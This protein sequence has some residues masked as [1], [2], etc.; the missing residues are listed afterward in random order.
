MSE[1]DQEPTDKKLRDARDKGEVVRSAEAVSALVFIGVLVALWAG[2]TVLLQHLYA[3]MHHALRIISSPDPAAQLGLFID[4]LLWEWIILA[5]PLLVLAAACG[6]AG[7]F[8]QVGGL[9]AWSR[10]VPKMERMDPAEGLKRIFSARSLINLVKMICMAVCLMG[11]LYSVI[12]SSLD[13]PLKAGSLAPDVILIVAGNLVQ[14]V[15]GW[16]A[17][18]F[19]IA[20]AIDY[21]HE[22]YQFMKS[23]R[24][25]IEDIRREH[26]DS[27]GDPHI[28]SRRK[29][30]AEEMQF[31][32]LVDRV[33]VAAVVIYSHRSAVALYFTGEGDVPRVVARGEGEAGMKIRQYAEQYLIPV[34]ENPDLAQKLYERVALD[35]FIAEDLY[36]PV[37]DVLRWAEG[38]QEQE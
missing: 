3:L 34:H 8:F 27:E 29:R 5:L 7:A 20:A 10:L 17:V 25:S 36:E 26:R 1:K 4:R 6:I 38:S 30:M 35:Q 37:A 21:L 19:V 22:H 24:M 9:A 18:V 28:N 14:T 11:V 12:L 2:G 32:L 33:R 23:Q 16:S 31:D 15:F 13:V